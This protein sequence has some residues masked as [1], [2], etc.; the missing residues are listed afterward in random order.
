MASGR[1]TAER[2]GPRDSASP[3]QGG[4]GCPSSSGP[5][6]WTEAG[7]PRSQGWDKGS[8]GED[9]ITGSLDVA[10]SNE[11]NGPRWRDGVDGEEG[12]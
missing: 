8:E 10:S 11:M 2:S 9:D 5:A 7:D 1:T 3:N 12:K 6:R 4:R